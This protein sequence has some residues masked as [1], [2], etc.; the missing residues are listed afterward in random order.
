MKKQVIFVWV[1]GLESL[2]NFKQVTK[3]NGI[4]VITSNVMRIAYRYILQ[5]RLYFL[6]YY[7]RLYQEVCDCCIFDIHKSF[8]LRLVL[9]TR[10]DTRNFIVSIQFRT[11]WYIHKICL[12][13]VCFRRFSAWS[14]QSISL[15]NF[16]ILTSQ[17]QI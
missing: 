1:G 6:R 5:F 17:Y 12:V 16:I 7:S 10:F 14:F 4:L 11:I 9:K 3:R 13:I 8:S 15:Y 2:E